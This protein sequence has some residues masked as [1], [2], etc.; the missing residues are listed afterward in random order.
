MNKNFW[1]IGRQEIILYMIER[2]CDTNGRMLEAGCGEGNVLLY[3]K[4]KGINIEG[5]DISKDSLQR[6][7]EDVNLYYLDICEMNLDNQF[8]IVGCFDVLE[9]IEDDRLALKNFYNALT[10][11]GRMILTVP[12]CSLLWSSFDVFGKHFRRYDGAGLQNKLNDAGFKIIRFSHFMFLLFPVM[13]VIRFFSK[14]KVSG[15]VEINTIPILNDIFL[16]VFRLDKL[17]MKYVN[18]PYGSSI[19]V[20]A[21]KE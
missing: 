2:Y 7:L 16:F 13:F 19:M 5:C 10:T 21:E 14:K 18:L 4:N 15:F 11:K 9:H 8:D 20:V 12:A 17:L 1:H 3:L 6:C